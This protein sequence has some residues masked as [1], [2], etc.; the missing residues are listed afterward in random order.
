MSKPLQFSIL[1]VTMS[2][3][4]DWI[5]LLRYFNIEEDIAMS[6]VN[7]PYEKGDDTFKRVL[8]HAGIAFLY[9]GSKWR[10]H[11]EIPP[12]QLLPQP[13]DDAAACLQGGGALSD[14]AG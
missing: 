12:L 1:M 14:A 13:A 10:G 6:I 3:A 8:G 5:S 9:H 11:L 2:M 7:V 4:A